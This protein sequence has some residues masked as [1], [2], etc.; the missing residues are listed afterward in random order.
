MFSLRTPGD[1]QVFYD[2]EFLRKKLVPFFRVLS[3]T[4]EAYGYQTALLLER[5]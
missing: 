1:C 5:V 3:V 4:E 2:I